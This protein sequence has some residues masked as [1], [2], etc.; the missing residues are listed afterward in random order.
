VKFPKFQPQKPKEF[1]HS[2]PQK[3]KPKNL[4][5]RIRAKL[6]FGITVKPSGKDYKP[7][8]EPEPDFDNIDSESEIEIDESEE[9]PEEW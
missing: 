1:K 9:Y 3:S 5:A 4:L 6:K 2:E 7:C 8:E